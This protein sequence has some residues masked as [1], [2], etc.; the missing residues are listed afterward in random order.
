MQKKGKWLSADCGKQLK[1]CQKAK[2]NRD[3]GKLVQL[4]A[5]FRRLRRN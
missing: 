4:N 5:E 1:Q 2:T 3:R